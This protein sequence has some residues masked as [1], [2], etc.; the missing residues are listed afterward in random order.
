MLAIAPQGAWIGVL[1]SLLACRARRT[2][3]FAMS[4]LKIACSC[5]RQLTSEVY[6]RPTPMALDQVL[7]AKPAKRT[8]EQDGSPGFVG[9]AHETE[10]IVHHAVGMGS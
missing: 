4:L 10:K 9:F 6:S 2:P 8:E 7:E 5:G 3:L 1:R